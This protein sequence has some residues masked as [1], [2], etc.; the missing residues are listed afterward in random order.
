MMNCYTA[1]FST[2]QSLFWPDCEITLW[3]KDLEAAEREARR[4]LVSAG[5]TMFVSA[6]IFCCDDDGELLEQSNVEL[7]VTRRTERVER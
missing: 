2:D 3:E 7:V 1:R 5:N 6:M 4:L